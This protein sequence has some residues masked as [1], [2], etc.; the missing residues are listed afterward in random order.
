MKTAIPFIIFLILNFAAL[1]L[2]SLFTQDGVQSDWYQ[3]LSKAPWT[4]P[5]WVFGLAWSCIMIC[6]AFYMAKLWTIILDKKKLIIL[7]LFQWILNIS[8]NPLFF[9]FHQ[10]SLALVIILS[11]TGL[12]GYF[13]WKYR[14]ELGRASFWIAP[15]LI[16]LL[17]ASSLNAY[18]LIFN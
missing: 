15:Y 8:W 9:Y 14:I 6:F 5:G 11:L 17:L 13:Y 10:V 1:A 3:N 7:F 4:P 18:I 2:G 16:W 12:V